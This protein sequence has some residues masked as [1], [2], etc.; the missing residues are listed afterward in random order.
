[1]KTESWLNI[2]DRLEQLEESNK[3]RH[4]AFAQE[5]AT[6]AAFREW[7]SNALASFFTQFGFDDFPNPP[8]A[9]FG[10]SSPPDDPG[11]SRRKSSPNIYDSDS[12]TQSE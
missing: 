6:A 3:K 1:M 5:R 8:P 12:S 11:P 10:P 4:E 2:E 9:T 7:T